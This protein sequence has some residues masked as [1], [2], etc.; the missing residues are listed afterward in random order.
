MSVRTRYKHGV[1]IHAADKVCPGYVLFTPTFTTRKQMQGTQYSTVYLI[2]QKGDIVHYWK[3]PGMVKLHGELLDNGHLLCAVDDL[4]LPKT[5]SFAFSVH[6]L[7]EL[8]WDSNVVWRYDDEYMDCHDRCRLR[9]GNTLIQRYQKMDPAL[10][11]RVRGG[12]AGTENKG[13]ATKENTDDFGWRLG[14]DRP[15]DM[16]TLVLQEITPAGQ[17]IWEMNCAQALDPEIDII[18]PYAG[19]ELWPG[20]NSIEEMPDGNIIST[21]YNLSTIFIW[22]KAAKTV[23]WRFGNMDGNPTR[24]RLSFPH[25]PTVLPNGHI[26]CFDN[27]R[28]HCADPDGSMNLSPPD[29]SRVIE[30]DSVRNEIVWE[31]RA[32]DPVDFYSTYISSARRLS[33]GNTIICEG[34]LGRFFEVTLAG[35]VVWEY[36][37]P[38]YTESVSRFGKTNNIFRCMKYEP[39]HPA[40]KG[41]TFDLERTDML[42]RLYGAEAYDV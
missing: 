24:H 30:I 12:V 14:N 25:D 1:T 6:A 17:V 38:I 2:D 3:V 8:D 23:K 41:R 33:N 11:A 40:L 20:L 18:T 15:G 9:N 32:E 29:F 4:Q 26:M 39:D 35:E 7:L 34:A 19:R 31:Y 36:V 22:D 10:Q 16:Y 28:F 27:G 42:N 37:S 5:L 21:S 13:I